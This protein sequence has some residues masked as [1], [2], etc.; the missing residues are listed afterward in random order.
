MTSTAAALGIGTTLDHEGVSYRFSPWTYKIQGEFERH[1]EDHAL[2]TI[3]RMKVYCS[4]GEYRELLASVHRDI[5]SGY[6]N[7]GGP[8][9]AQAMTTL[10][11]LVVLVT[12][13]LKPNH[14][15]ISAATV[16]AILKKQMEEV[17]DKMSA[18]NADP[19]ATSP[20][21]M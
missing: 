12:L 21:S 19:N 3:K 20:A 4:D 7:F 17:L 6:Y 8:A 2:K 16:E 9:V 1:L 11:H 18:A 13:C 10:H 5:S 15:D 14:P